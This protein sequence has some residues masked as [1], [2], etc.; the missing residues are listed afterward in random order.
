MK[1][2]KLRDNQQG[3]A[4]VAFVLLAIIVVGGIAWSGYAVYKAGHKTATNNVAV[5]DNKATSAPII[6]STPAPSQSLS[7]STQ[8]TTST[9]DTTKTTAPASTQSTTAQPSP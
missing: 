3:M 8:T 4:H 5:K 7:T 6:V 9:A 2:A 1:Y